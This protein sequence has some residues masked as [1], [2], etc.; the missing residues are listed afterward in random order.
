MTPTPSAKASIIW[1]PQ[2]KQHALLTCP[3]EDVFFGGARGGGKSDGLIGDWMAH[4]YQYGKHAKGLLIRRTY[5]ELEELE[6]RCLAIFSQLGARLHRHSR[7]WTM[8]WG[9]GN[10][11]MRHLRTVADASLYQGHSYTWIGVDELTHW[12]M[13]EPI[14]L[15]RATLRSPAGVK[16]VMRHTGNPGGAG[17][18]WV[19]LRYVDS[20]PPMR[21]H[22]DEEH[23]T[24]RTF[25]PSTLDDNK[26]LTRNDPLYWRRVEASAS[27]KAYLLKAW[28]YGLWDIA[29]GG[30]FEQVWDRDT[31]TI[32]PFIIP[33]GWRVD[34]SLDW[35]SSKPFCVLWFAESNGEQ[36]TLANGQTKSYP[37]GTLFVIA[38][39]YGYAGKPN[40][41][42]GGE[43][44]LIAGRVQAMEQGLR[45]R[46]YT[47]HVFPGPGDDP[48]FDSG[49]GKSMAE[50]MQARG[51]MWE[52]P[53]KGPG[54]RVTGWQAISSRLR[55]ALVESPEQPGLYIFDTC[56]HL[57]R[58]LPVLP[59]D[60]C[61]PDDVDTEAEDHAPDALRLRLLAPDMSAGRLVTRGY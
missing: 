41:G 20:A 25:I 51:V 4:A 40:A 19:K 38:E 36:V 32:Q 33:S 59:R 46:L 50:V 3:V 18:S 16:C 28:R 57:L 8:P 17:H 29:A 37:P 35:G 2:P 34:R 10:L 52:R 31:H 48:I 60:A 26:V 55:A 42:I 13:P 27:G 54:S 58:T 14:D 7:T 21:P 49:R 30:I 43:P 24:E 56:T 61:N 47:G 23:K 6:A 5:P 1:K 44:D 53:S 45:Q 11:R 12:A 22:M 9:G 39:E 15:L